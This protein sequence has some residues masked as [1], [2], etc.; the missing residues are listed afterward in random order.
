MRRIIEQVNHN[1]QINVY[2]ACSVRA[3]ELLSDKTNQV[4]EV[5]TPALYAGIK[6]F[7]DT[8]IHAKRP[9]DILV[10]AVH[11]EEFDGITTGSTTIIKAPAKPEAIEIRIDVAIGGGYEAVCEQPNLRRKAVVGANDWRS[12]ISFLQH[13][14]RDSIIDRLAKDHKPLLPAHYTQKIVAHELKH[15]LDFTD[16]NKTATHQIY[17]AAC[18]KAIDTLDNNRLE[19][20]LGLTGAIYMAARKLKLSRELSTTIG[21]IS[22]MGVIALHEILSIMDVIQYA[23]AP[24]EIGACRAEKLAE[25][26]PQIITVHNTN[27]NMCL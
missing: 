10:R 2:T 26:I 21:V 18:S 7:S 22:S 6:L 14:G 27:T 16:D 17:D 20:L 4:I 9:I 24:Y 25:K 15:A 3:G 12:K 5:N 23:L 11:E 8:G 13:A 19:V 1:P